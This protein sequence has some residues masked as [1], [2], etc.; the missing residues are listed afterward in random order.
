MSSKRAAY[1]R[2]RAIVD[3][4]NVLDGRAIFGERAA[5]VTLERQLKASI[6]QHDAV[7]ARIVDGDDGA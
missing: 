4:E 2:H 6:D 1:A 7:M 5:K 3:A